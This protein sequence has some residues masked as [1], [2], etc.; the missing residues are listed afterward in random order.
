MA[1]K[2]DF[3]DNTP[4]KQ[5]FIVKDER[6]A[7]RM[8]REETREA[9]AKYRAIVAR[10]REAA[11]A[12]T[13]APRPSRRSFN[14]GSLPAA[15]CRRR[16]DRKSTRLNSSHLVTSYAV[17]CLKKTNTPASIRGF[18]LFRTVFL[19]WP[20]PRLTTVYR[21]LSSGGGSGASVFGIGRTT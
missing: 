18:R 6:A 4:N 10:E 19:R 16:R 13:A 8:K 3:E 1:N 7:L 2:D 12:A 9:E 14:V 17:F 21:L 5:T 15:A 11:R 20:K